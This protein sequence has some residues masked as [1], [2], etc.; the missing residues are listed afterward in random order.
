MKNATLLIALMALIFGISV[1]GCMKNCW[2]KPMDSKQASF[3]FKAGD[4][5][6]IWNGDYTNAHVFGS[7]STLGTSSGQDVFTIYA[8]GFNGDGLEIALYTSKFQQGQFVNV[9]DV[10]S[11]EITGILNHSSWGFDLH[12]DVSR[13]TITSI[14]DNLA[15]GTFDG[16]LM[17]GSN[18]VQATITNGEF[19]NVAILQ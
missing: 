4:S 12:N 7:R 15:D 1:T 6:Y 8:K 16:T 2:N 14:H 11:L 10:Q 9:P 13:L 17:M 18:K 5:T 3:T 19:H